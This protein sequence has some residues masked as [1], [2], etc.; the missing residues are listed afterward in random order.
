MRGRWLGGRVGE[1]RKT[2]WRSVFG[3]SVFKIGRCGE[4]R[5]EELISGVCEM[6][7]EKFVALWTEAQVDGDFVRLKLDAI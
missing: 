6:L 1:G 4:G 2:F 5:S 3:V 7:T